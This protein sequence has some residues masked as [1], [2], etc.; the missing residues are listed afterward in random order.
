MSDVVN[1][2]SAALLDNSATVDTY[3]DQSKFNTVLLI[4]K[5]HNSWRLIAV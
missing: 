3:S 5:A 4:A 2:N 1:I